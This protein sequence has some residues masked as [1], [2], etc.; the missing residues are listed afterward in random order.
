M[1]TTKRSK[2]N[3]S[4]PANRNARAASANTIEPEQ[5]LERGAPS[6]VVLEAGDQ[7]LNDAPTLTLPVMHSEPEPEFVPPAEAPAEPAAPQMQAPQPAPAEPVAPLP[8][9]AEPVAQ[10]AATGATIAV[11]PP[12]AAPAAAAPSVALTPAEERAAYTRRR[13]VA[14]A[15]LLAV[16]LIVG[17]LA[18]RF[19]APQ[20][21][22]T[23]AAPA[24]PIAAQQPAAPEAGA[25]APAAQQPAAPAGADVIGNCSAVPGLPVFDGAT[26]TKQDRDDDDGQIKLENTY[27]ANVPAADVKTFYESA[28]AANGWTIAN[29]DHDA[30]DGQWEYS[31]TQGQRE[32]KVKIE[33]QEVTQGNVTEFTIAED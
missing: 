21:G 13:M 3:A 8:A 7:D 31:L 6:S 5:A 1:A 20:I 24:A 2:R 27:V 23:P 33:A 17:F 28:F 19:I 9:S 15:G 26:C 22:A 12:P 4:S 29:T 11:N 18:Y 10:Q 25:G 16:L 32:L 30:E 14:L